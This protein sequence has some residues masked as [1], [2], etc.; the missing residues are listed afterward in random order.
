MTEQNIGINEKETQNNAWEQHKNEGQTFGIVDYLHTEIAADID[1]DMD[2]HDMEA[3][4]EI[5]VRVLEYILTQYSL[6]KRL[7]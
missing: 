1:N 5:E 3:S 4:E 7:K 2:M 6:G